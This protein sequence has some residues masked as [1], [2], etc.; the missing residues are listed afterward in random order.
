MYRY[1][2]IVGSIDS[3]TSRCV[4][5]RDGQSACSLAGVVSSLCDWQGGFRLLLTLFFSRPLWRRSAPRPQALQPPAAIKRRGEPACPWDPATLY[6]DGRRTVPLTEG[7]PFPGPPLDALFS[8][9]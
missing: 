6:A 4:R 3:I 2:D 5:E 8:R 9:N 7:R 1:F